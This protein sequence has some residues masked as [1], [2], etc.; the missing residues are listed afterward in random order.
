M[1][2]RRFSPD[3]RALLAALGSV[4]L[5]P[6]LSRP[7]TAQAGA[8]LALTLK[9]GTLDLRQ[10][11]P[12]SPVWSLTTAASSFMSHI[13]QGD[14]VAVAVAVANELP[15]PT[16]LA[17]RGLDGGAS[18]AALT[19]QPPMASGGRAAF[20]LPA[21]HSGTFLFDSGLLG[22]GAERP[23]LGHVLTAAETTAV[24][25]DRDEVLLIEDWRLDGSGK[26]LAPG[27][28]TDATPLFTVNR[29]STFDIDVKSNERLRLRIVNGCQRALIALKIADHDVRVM[30]IDSQPAEPFIARDGQLVLA[31]GTRIDA[32]LD[33]TRPPGSASEILLHDGTKAQPVGRILT[34]KDTAR[35]ALLPPPA[36][37]P[38]NG[39]P[40]R[41]D[42]RNALRV[43]VALDPAALWVT[44]TK[45][46]KAAAPAFRAKRGRI[47][48][49]A[50]KNTTASAQVFRLHGHHCRLLD[51]L[52]DGW[53]PFWLDTLALQPGETQRI[54]FAAEFAGNWLIETVA[55][56]WSAPRLVRWFAVE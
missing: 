9:P 47:V 49:L 56:V 28:A 42:L 31:P 16:V 46:D 13:R 2:N 43:D 51:K 27:R 37:L 40:A 39:L 52:D 55:P 12:A 22:D 11:P 14:N 4:A 17:C 15:V 44:P 53:K 38:L 50:L 36:P 24:T 23:S 30:A 21:R 18:A 20:A 32:F 34:A 10:G 41:L 35:A 54:A 7:V 29:K 5:A 1:E 26:A 19:A 6:V 48:V 45:F 33:A 3:R 25:A 8:S